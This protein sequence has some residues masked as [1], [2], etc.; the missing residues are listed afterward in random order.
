[1]TL[2]SRQM[3]TNRPILCS[4]MECDPAMSMR[5]EV[6]SL[7]FVWRG[8]STGALHHPLLDNTPGMD[9]GP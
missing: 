6:Q 4:V 2:K 7:Y 5:G 9:E 8:W 3:E 1:M